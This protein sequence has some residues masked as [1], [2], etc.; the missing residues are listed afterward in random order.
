MWFMALV[1]LTIVTYIVMAH[2]VMAYM[3]HGPRGS[4]DR[5][6]YSYGL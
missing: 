2:K 4:D 5:Q 6:L 1:A 3:V